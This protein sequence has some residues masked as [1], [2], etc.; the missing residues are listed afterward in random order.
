MCKTKCYEAKATAK[1][2]KQKA[3]QKTNCAK[4]NATKQKT[5][6]KSKSKSKRQ[7]QKQKANTK[8][9]SKSKSDTNKQIVQNKCYEAK[10]T[11][12]GKK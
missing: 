10:A 12:K 1:S 2:K 8:A 3:I 9:K 11:A 4:Q 6:A 5:K 7:K